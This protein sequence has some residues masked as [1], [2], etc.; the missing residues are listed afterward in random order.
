MEG[1]GV[2]ILLVIILSAIISAIIGSNNRRSGFGFFFLGLL[3]G[4]I[5]IAIALIMGTN[6]EAIKMEEIKS[7]SLIKCPACAENIK[8]E[9]NICRYC[10]SELSKQTWS[11][12]INKENHV[13]CPRCQGIVALDEQDLTAKSFDCPRCTKHVIFS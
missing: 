8:A 4:P 1:I 7:G 3:L 6:S 9:A 13:N 10:Q 12:K 2:I 5:A 11:L